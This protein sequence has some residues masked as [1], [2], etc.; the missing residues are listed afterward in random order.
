MS[1]SCWI[2]LRTT[3]A[4]KRRVKAAAKKA[5]YKMTVSRFVE[6]TLVAACD[7]IDAKEKVC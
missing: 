6:A 1:E 2:T 3:Q 4:I 5:G 7:A